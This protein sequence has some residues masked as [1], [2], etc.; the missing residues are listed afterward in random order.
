[1]DDLLVRRLVLG[2]ILVG[3]LVIIFLMIFRS[4]GFDKAARA[5]LLV[6]K[7]SRI[8]TNFSTYKHNVPD[9]DAVE[10]TDIRDLHKKGK[11]TAGNIINV[12]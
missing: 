11:F 7:G 4:E 8:T 6:A 5:D 3:V 12:L 9:G 1:M 2:C 10:Y